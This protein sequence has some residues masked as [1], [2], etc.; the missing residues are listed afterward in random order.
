MKTDAGYL[1]P[2]AEK[3]ESC[4]HDLFRSPKTG[5]TALYNAAQWDVALRRHVCWTVRV[6]QRSDWH[7]RPTVDHPRGVIVAF[8]EPLDHW[9]SSN[10][11]FHRR[12]LNRYRISERSGTVDLN[13]YVES[14]K[15]AAKDAH[16]KTGQSKYLLRPEDR[17]GFDDA[18]V[19]VGGGHRPVHEQLRRIF[20]DP[21]ICARAASVRRPSRARE[22]A[23]PQ[24]KSR[25]PTNCL[26]ST[27]PC[28]QT[29]LC[30]SRTTSSPTTGSGAASAAT[31]VCP[32]PGEL[33]IARLRRT[34]EG[35]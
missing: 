19:C 22:R 29:T 8:R 35:G 3:N 31:R 25:S 24:V 20:D 28:L 14:F 6:Q 5:S 21:E 12:D 27:R 11:F 10:L 2:P 15:Q 4:T 17:P 32:R 26:S 30:G 13:R 16:G 34:R 1:L 18:V 33:E 7:K 9:V 23:P